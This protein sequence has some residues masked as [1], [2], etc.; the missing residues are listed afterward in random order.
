[1]EKFRQQRAACFRQDSRLHLRVVIEP[2]VK[3]GADRPDGTA[4]PVGGSVDHPGN[5]GVDDGTGAHG[6]RL[7]RYIQG[8]LPQPPAPKGFA[9]LGDGLDLR[10]SQGVFCPLPAVPT[11]A[12]DP[13]VPGDDAAHGH[14]SRVKGLPCQLQSRAHPFLVHDIPPLTFKVIIAEELPRRQ[15]YDSKNRKRILSNI[16]RRTKAVFPPTMKKTKRRKRYGTD[17]VF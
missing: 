17:L 16:V 9:G 13:A 4:F 10:V 7:Q 5:P 1:M 15:G 6:A 11:P 2:H 3:K 12:D 8:A 14:L